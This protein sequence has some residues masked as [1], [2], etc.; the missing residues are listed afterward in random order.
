MY[1]D[2]GHVLH[3]DF[4]FIFDIVPGGVKF[5]A[6]PFKLTKEMVSVLGGSKNSLG[7]KLFEK[8]TI[9]AFLA[10]RKHYKFIQN[11]IEPMMDSNLPCFGGKTIKHLQARLAL[12][13]S[14]ADAAVFMKNKITRSY[15]SN[16]TK[17][18]DEFQKMTNGIPY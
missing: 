3:I 17:G 9:K 4:G 10:L 7:Y 8:L 6:V 11:T 5:E 1:D 14:E 16:F 13:K 15:E 12:D 2:Y 18:Y